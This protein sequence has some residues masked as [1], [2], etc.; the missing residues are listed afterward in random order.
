VF[1]K[2][3]ASIFK[4]YF[5]KPKISWTFYGWPWLGLRNWECSCWKAVELLQQ[6]LSFLAK[7]NF[8][9]VELL[10]LSWASSAA[11]ELFSWTKLQLS[12]ASSAAIELFQLSWTSSTTVELFQL[13]LSFLN[14]SWTLTS[15]V[16][17]SDHTP[18]E[19]AFGQL[20]WGFLSWTLWSRPV[21]LVFRGS[22]TGLW[23]LWPLTN[24]LPVRLANRST[25][26]WG[27]VQPPP[28]RFNRFGQLGQ[29]AHQSASQTGEQ[30]DRV[31]RGGSTGLVNLAR[32]HS[33]LPVRLTVRSAK[34]VQ[35]VL[36]NLTSLCSRLPG[37]PE[38]VQLP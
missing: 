31:V 2:A 26:S 5:W 25:E 38:A 23:P 20:N 22:S 3:Q 14:S 16:N 27:A 10:Q 7:L 30:V 34:E 37:L 13:Q 9:L 1:A 32:L 11:V 8:S 6:Q 33:S 15:T 24:S 35:P 18:V 17:L 4:S 19:L 21:E 28:G 36:V 12:W 29:T